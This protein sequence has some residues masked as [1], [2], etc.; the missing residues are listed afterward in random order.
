[1]F[2]SITPHR[3]GERS[4]LLDF[5]K[6]QIDRM[7]L[8]PDYSYFIDYKPVNTNV[9]LV[10][11]VKV[12][13]EQAIND[14]FE[15]A[16]ILENDDFY[17]PNYFK[18]FEPAMNRGEDFLGVATTTYYNLKNRTW[19]KF[20]H[21]GRSSLFQTGF[22]LAALKKFNWPTNKT[23]MLDLYIWAHARVSK[24]HLTRYFHQEQIALG[25]K[26]GQGVC[27]GK[28][29]G[30]ELKHKDQHHAFL[31]SSVDLEAFKFYMTL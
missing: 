4:R 3:G 10:D 11:R 12:G 22:R 30:M 19:Q 15:Y 20:E 5:C 21:P 25:I 8:K 14:G 29:H 17:S 24:N 9:D 18:A 27:G 6:V 16:F 23:V 28:A 26:H 1:M 2:C 31:K 13:V 7:T